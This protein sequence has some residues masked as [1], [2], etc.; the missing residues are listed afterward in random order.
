MI[1]TSRNNWFGLKCLLIVI[2]LLIFCNT[3]AWGQVVNIDSGKQFN[4][5]QSAI[6]NARPHESLLVKKGTYLEFD[7]VVDKPICISAEEKAVIDVQEKGYGFKITADSV[8][9]QGLTIKNTGQSYTKDFAAIYVSRST[10]F[11]L[12]NN[13]LENVTFGMLVEKSKSGSIGGNTIFGTKTVEAAAG[14]GIHLWDCS[15]V[16]ITDNEVH[17]LRDGIYFE[18]VTHSLVQGNSSHDNIRYGLH[19]MFSNNDEYRYNE[20]T[21]NGAGVAVMF[22]KFININHNTFSHNWGTAAYGILLKEIYDTTISY[23]IIKENTIGINVEGS[24]RIDYH[25]NELVK[26]GWAVKVRGACYNNSFTRNNFKYNSFDVSYNSNMN[27]NSFTE[28]YWSNY[29]GYDLDRDDIGDVPHRP[30]K[31]FSYVVN[32]TPETIILLRSL[33]VDIIDFSEKVSP[34]FTPEELID[35]QP[36]MNPLKL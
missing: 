19:F 13:Q 24:T 10:H 22:S 16:I 15:E 21:N 4:T 3:E 14:N 11:N 9:I 8:S 31:L 27:D 29:S 2:S 30:V 34:V 26:N 23:N 5:V 7:I 28:N 1:K 35:P 36:L 25:H 12:Q 6:F 20:F 18:F 32:E 33:F 17:H